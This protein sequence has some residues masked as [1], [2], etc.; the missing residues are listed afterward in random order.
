MGAGMW[1][2]WADHLELFLAHFRMGWAEMH[3][4]DTWESCVTTAAALLTQ[5]SDLKRIFWRQAEL[6]Q[7]QWEKK[8]YFFNS[9]R[10]DAVKSFLTQLSLIPFFPLLPVTAA[11]REMSWLE[12]CGQ[13]AK[14]LQF[15]PFPMLN[16]H[17]PKE[18]LFLGSYSALEIKRKRP[19]SR[20]CFW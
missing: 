14:Q 13:K 19:E 10:K 12:D 9:L 2:L 8:K 17:I 6:L 5:I 18:N 16:S 7:K 20:E 11:L 4:W 3:P 1:P 15:L